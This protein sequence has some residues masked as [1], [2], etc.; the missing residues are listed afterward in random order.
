MPYMDDLLLEKTHHIA[1][2]KSVVN[3]QSQVIISEEEKHSLDSY[4]FKTY[5]RPNAVFEAVT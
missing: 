1:S 3:K 2:Q 4:F 5:Y